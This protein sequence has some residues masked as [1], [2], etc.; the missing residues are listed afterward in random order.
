MGKFKERA[1]DFL[2]FSDEDIFFEASRRIQKNHKEKLGC[3]LRW[4]RINFDFL[5][6]DFLGIQTEDGQTIFK[7]A[8]SIR[9]DSKISEYENDIGNPYL[10]NQMEGDINA[11]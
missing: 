8:F 6:G 5:D 10:N 11:S 1:M 4:G 9:S 7:T 2:I 3:D